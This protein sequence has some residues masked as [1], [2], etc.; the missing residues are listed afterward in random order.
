MQGVWRWRQEGGRGEGEWGWGGE[1]GGLFIVRIRH[2]VLWMCC[3]S[4]NRLGEPVRLSR[5]RERA[6]PGA[7]CS[8][9]RAMEGGVVSLVASRWA[10]W[11]ASWVTGWPDSGA[12]VV[13]NICCICFP[14]TCLYLSLSIFVS[15]FV[16]FAPYLAPYVRTYIPDMDVRS[17]TYGRK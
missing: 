9:R 5:W 7:C 12:A 16:L 8:L 1:R 13:T 2:D 11:P 4:D 14:L 10:G 6:T 17:R 15:P 3:G